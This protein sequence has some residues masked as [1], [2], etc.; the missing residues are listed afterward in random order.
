MDVHPLGEIDASWFEH[1]DDLPERISAGGVVM[2][3]AGGLAHVALVREIDEDGRTLEGYVLPKG[4]VEPDE[5]VDTAAIREVEEEAGLT[6]IT[7]LS[8]LATL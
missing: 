5:A 1:R 8:D 3:V 2:R 4:G 7:K 6:E